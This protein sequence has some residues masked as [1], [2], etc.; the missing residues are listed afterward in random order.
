MTIEAYAPNDRPI[1]FEVYD[2]QGRL[3]LVTPVSSVAGPA[4]LPFRLDLSSLRPGVYFVRYL[5]EES[6]APRGSRR[7][8]VTR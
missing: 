8:V 7:I 6:T 1:R 5:G 4:I 3:R 2:V